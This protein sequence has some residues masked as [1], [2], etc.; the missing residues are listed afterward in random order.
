MS[1]TDVELKNATQVAYEEDLAVAFQAKVDAGQQP[2]F[3]IH[4]LCEYQGTTVEEM[5]GDLDGQD[6]IGDWKIMDIRDTNNENGFF[7]C[8]IDTGDG[9]AIVAFRGS[10]S[11]MDLNQLQ[12]D[13]LDADLG[14]LNSTLTA[15]QQEAYNFMKQIAESDYIDNYDSL[16]M[17]GHSLG[18][19]LAQHATIISEDPNIGLSDKIDQCVNFDGPGFSQEYIEK[20]GDWIEEVNDK[21]THY[22]WSPVG[23][24]LFELPGVPRTPLKVKDKS[25]AGYYIIGKHATSSIEFNEDGSAKR[26]EPTI[27]DVMTSEFSQGIERLPAWAGDILV[28][29]VSTLWYGGIWMY[30]QMVDEDGKLTPFGYMVIAAAVTLV[31]KLGV[32]TTLKMVVAIIAVVVI[33][34]L[35]V[36]ALEMLYDLVEFVMTKIAEAVVAVCEWLAE[37]LDE[38]KEMITQTIKKIKQWYKENFDKGYQYA[39]DHPT[40]QLDTYKLRNYASRLR[41]VNSRIATLDRDLD[42]LYKKVGLL[43]LWNLMQADIL[44]GYSWR[45]LRC[46]TYLEET[47]RDFES[48]E[49]NLA[50]SI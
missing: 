32:I 49:N 42:S 29:I 18:G 8:V 24:L 5:F 40:I 16:A 28:G 3:S 26:G 20:Y 48:V 30:K 21:M 37:K 45:L 9:N 34:F 14:L 44:T 36:V 19:N 43:D 6:N 47:A 1:Y 41:K 33:A 35:V 38:I 39:T 15:Q 27:W 2:P 13:W 46:A 23:G 50:K 25:D 17:T 31:L 22:R 11:M 7:G 12:N 10:E 4:D